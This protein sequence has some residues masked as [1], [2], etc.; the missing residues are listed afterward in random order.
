MS[1]SHEEW[2]GR[3]WRAD[4]RY[5]D[6]LARTPEGWRLAEHRVHAAVIEN[7]REIDWVWVPR[8]EPDQG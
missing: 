2:A 8:R 3:Q 5:L 7:R 4:L 6:V 1:A